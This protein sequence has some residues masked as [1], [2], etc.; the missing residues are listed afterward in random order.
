M[1]IYTIQIYTIPV[2]AGKQ[3]YT[4]GPGGDF[5]LPARP[6]QLE[7][8]WFQQ[9]ITAPFNDI[10]MTLISERDWGNIRAKAIPSIIGTWAYYDQQYPLA[11]LY[12][13]PIPNAAGNLIIHAQQLLN[14]A[15]A[16]TDTESLPMAYRRAVRFNLACVLAA[17]N[18]FEP[19]P[20][21]QAT[22]VNTLAALERNNGQLAQRMDFDDG[23]MG[24]N[25]SRYIIYSDSFRN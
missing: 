19:A 13:W 20:T 25:G 21:V 12:I 4:V 18:G 6:P 23:A 2:Q 7:G 8:I 15:V 10:P 5:N 24:N 16:L 22:A 11:N 9:L 3:I 1:M 14:S 17:E